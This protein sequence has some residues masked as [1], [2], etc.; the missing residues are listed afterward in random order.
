V[1]RVVNEHPSVAP[2]TRKKVREAIQRLNYTPSALARGLQSNR[3]NTIGVLLAGISFTGPAHTLAGITHECAERNLTVLMAEMPD[4]Y[5]FDAGPALQS[6][7][8]H[9]VDG[10]VMSV[11]EVGSSISRIAGVLADSPAPIVFVRAAEL[12][13]Y[14]GLLIDNAD[15]IGQAVD[16]LVSLGRSRIAHIAGPD[17]WREATARLRGWRDGLG[18]HG[19]DAPDAR[20]AFG[21]WTAE[22]GARAMR[23]ILDEDPDVDAVVAANDHMALGAMRVLEHTGRVVPDDVAVT[24]FDNSAEAAWGAPSLTSVDQPLEALGRAAVRTV[25]EHRADRNRDVTVDSLPCELIVRESTAGSPAT[26]DFDRL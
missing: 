10:I 11:P 16:H 6:F 2:E 4:L 26:R 7:V 15:G 24:G 3:S 1:S 13:G 8:E 9:R 25:L 18:R 5:D 23:S 21:D 14:S 12:P 22:S 17:G 19:L 20:R